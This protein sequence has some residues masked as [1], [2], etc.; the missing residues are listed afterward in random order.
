MK[1]LIFSLL[2]LILPVFAFAETYSCDELLNDMNNSCNGSSLCI[3]NFNKYF[4]IIS[5]TARC[6]SLLSSTIRIIDLGFSDNFFH[7]TF[8]TLK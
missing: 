2:I 7:Q 8:F 4:E 3:D 5:D 1:K 6:L